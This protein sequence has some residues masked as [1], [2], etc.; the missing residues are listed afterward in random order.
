M[1]TEQT[2]GSKNIMRTLQNYAE[3][4]PA[5]KTGLWKQTRLVRVG[6]KKDQLEIRELNLFQRIL[7]YFTQ[8]TSA[9]KV[10]KMCVNSAHFMSMRN[11]VI[12]IF[13]YAKTNNVQKKVL[14][15]TPQKKQEWG[16]QVMLNC[17]ASINEGTTRSIN[18]LKHY[19]QQWKNFDLQVHKENLEKFFH[20][21]PGS[22][23][24]ALQ[25]AYD[26]QSHIGNDLSEVFRFLTD[27]GADINS[28][29]IVPSNLLM[30]EEMERPLVLQALFDGHTDSLKAILE[31]KPDLGTLCKNDKT[32][33]EEIESF[34]QK[35]PCWSSWDDLGYRQPGRY[36][37]LQ[38]CLTLIEEYIKQNK[39]EQKK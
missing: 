12:A 2:S 6:A 7:C 9:K 3:M 8:S 27:Q 18:A 24:A 30:Q 14:Q 32:C 17:I 21:F 25:A 26:C 10:L 13:T 5:K 11:N 1:S 20:D 16:K 36:N 22:Q 33:L 38:K 4:D 19:F 37:N 39:T 29:Q 31:Q 23:N 34:R 15:K 35:P 28:R